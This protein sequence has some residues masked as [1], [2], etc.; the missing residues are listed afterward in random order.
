[1]DFATLVIIIAVSP[2]TLIGILVLNKVGLLDKF[3]K[4]GKDYATKEEL[5]HLSETY[6]HNLTQVTQDIAII[7]TDLS[8]AKTNI[9]W[10][11]EAIKK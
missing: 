9:K 7:K 5:E 1:M 2:A 11:K 6:N 10:I 4:N 8:E 3:G